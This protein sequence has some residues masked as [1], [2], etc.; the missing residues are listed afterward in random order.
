MDLNAA[1]MAYFIDQA[2]KGLISFGFSD[3]DA[4]F[5]NATLNGKF[6]KRCAPA[7]TL[8]PSSA[9]PQLQAICIAPDCTISANDT[10]PAYG[11][12]K[13]PAVANATLA[14]NFTK[15]ANGQTSLNTSNADSSG[16]DQ[17]T[18]GGMPLVGMD[19]AAIFL[20]FISLW[21]I[22]FVSDI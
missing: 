17:P 8:I 6:N 7:E 16:A 2:V 4:Q 20:S 18:N 21:M 13:A 15:D 10:C 12:I 5:V 11:S 9:G 3:A 22:H 1:E 14:G 19:K